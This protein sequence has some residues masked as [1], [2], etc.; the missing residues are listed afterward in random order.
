MCFYLMEYKQNCTK[1]YV[2]EA[3]FCEKVFLFVP[4]LKKMYFFQ[5]IQAETIF[6]KKTIL[7]IKVTVF[8]AQKTFFF[9]L[10]GEKDRGIYV[11]CFKSNK[12]AKNWTGNACFAAIGFE[13]NNLVERKR[14]LEPE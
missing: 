5:N 9:F 11:L 1:I 6:C 7:K 10:K 14:C 12:N 13:I 4:V 3:I 2:K 8:R